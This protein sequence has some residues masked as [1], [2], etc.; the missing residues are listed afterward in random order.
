MTTQEIRQLQRALGVKDDGIYGPKTQRA[1]QAHLD[2]IDTTPVPNITPVAA[3]PWWTSKALLGIIAA[4]IAW[5]ISRYGLNIDTDEITGILVNITEVAGAAL[6]I[7]GTIKNRAPI[8]PT[9]VARVAGRDVRLPM[10]AHR[11][12][13]PKYEPG[14]F[15]AH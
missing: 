9:L 3:K 10:P 4:G 12:S 2:A 5:C 1:H 7:Y 13:V 15:D 14:P 11:P 8:D 6:A